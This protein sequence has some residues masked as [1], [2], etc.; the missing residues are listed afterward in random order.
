MRSVWVF[1]LDTGACNG[2][3]I[4]LFDALTPYYDAERFG[5]KLV[6]SPRHAHAVLATG[7]LTRQS[8]HAAKEVI[9]AM[10]P[11]PRIIIAIGTCACSGGIFYNGYPI[12]RRPEDGRKGSEY[13]R[14]GGI[15]ELVRDLRD[16]GEPVGPV[17]YIPGCP[18]RPEEI[19]YGIALL[20]GLVEKRVRPEEH[21]A[22]GLEVGRPPIDERLRLTLRERL[23]H[24][25]GHF[26]ADRVL[27]DF[28][29]LVS[30]AKDEE[31]LHRLV[32][33]YRSRKDERLGACMELIETEYLRWKRGGGER[34]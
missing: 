32:E 7:P 28:M 3:E 31:E 33:D 1:H 21:E 15:D 18:P 12:H 30:R 4:E 27:E 6:G 34:S 11:K 13:P 29:G 25:I 5:V 20:L 2:C 17:M 26:D 10:P 19:L 23:R 14:R 24:V 16:E 9:K 8:Y 22:A